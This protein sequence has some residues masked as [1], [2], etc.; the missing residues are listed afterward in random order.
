MSNLELLP[1][2]W[3]TSYK[4]SMIALDDIS[5]GKPI[6]T[7]AM[8]E[9]DVK[10]IPSEKRADSIKFCIKHKYQLFGIIEIFTTIKTLNNI[11]TNFADNRYDR[12]LNKVLN[13]KKDLV[14]QVESYKEL[15]TNPD[16]LKPIIAAIEDKNKMLIPLE[17]P[18]TIIYEYLRERNIV[19]NDRADFL[20]LFNK[21]QNNQSDLLN[22]GLNLKIKL[23]NYYGLGFKTRDTYKK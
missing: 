18:S 3:E 12:Y 15:C 4:D 17:K 11:G 2:L 5:T 9:E 10:K 6:Y 8:L 13:Y 16:V 14:K 7:L 22:A 20:K 19:D 1:Y 21:T 23:H